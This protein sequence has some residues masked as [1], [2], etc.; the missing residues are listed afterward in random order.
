MSVVD[1]LTPSSVGF[2]TVVT[3]DEAVRV[4]DVFSWDVFSACLFGALRIGARTRCINEE[5]VVLEAVERR[6]VSHVDLQPFGWSRH[7]TMSSSKLQSERV[8]EGKRESEV[9]YEHIEQCRCPKT[10]R[11]EWRA[12]YGA[13]W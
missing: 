4:A 8:R 3:D 11:K 10:C 9:E 1:S 6:R 12:V 7:T 5:I 13:R 2:I